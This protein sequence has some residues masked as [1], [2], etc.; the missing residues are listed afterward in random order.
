MRLH[1]QTEKFQRCRIHTRERSPVWPSLILVRKC[2][3]FS[4]TVKQITFS[5]NKCNSYT[6]RCIS[7]VI[8]ISIV[9]KKLRGLETVHDLA[10]YQVSDLIS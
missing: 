5:F 9:C 4:V 7:V 1:F 8:F 2:I 3:F 10:G 6:F